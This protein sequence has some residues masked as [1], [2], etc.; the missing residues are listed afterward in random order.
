MKKP[1]DKT[2]AQKWGPRADLGAPV[3]GFFARQPPELRAIL[4][5]LRG[6]IERAAPGAVAAI[7][8]G[9]PMYTLDGAMMC[10]LGAHKAHV[11]LILSGPP[12]TYA[13]PDGLLEG[14]G[15]TGKHLKLR[16]LADVPRA[17]VRKWLAAAAA[18]ARAKV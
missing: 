5:L 8:W 12:G 16:T 15:K 17:A 10:A 18:T 3:D 9:M 13:D 2:P 7:K 11:N 6:E 14:D 1:T 4:E